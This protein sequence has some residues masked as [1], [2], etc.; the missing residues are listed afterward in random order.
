MVNI[1]FSYDKTINSLSYSFLGSIDFDLHVMTFPW[2][3]FFCIVFPD[4][5]VALAGMDF[6]IVLFKL[7]FNHWPGSVISWASNFNT[8]LFV[9]EMG[10]FL[11]VTPFLYDICVISSAIRISFTSAPFASSSSVTLAVFPAF[12]C[13][14]S[15][16]GFVDVAVAT[17]FSFTIADCWMK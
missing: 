12:V 17:R 1:S 5:S 14:K 6:D 4:V 9:N 3:I 8:V 2:E 13:S 16:V 15:V 10:L 11:H 7:S